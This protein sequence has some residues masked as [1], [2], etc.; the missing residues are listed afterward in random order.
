MGA[1]PASALALVTIP[2]MAEPMMEEEL[3]QLLSGAVDVLNKSSAPLVGGHSA[4]GA[5]LSIALTVTDA[6]PDY[7][8]EV[9]CPSRR[10]TYPDQTL[11][12]RSDSCGCDARYPCSWRNICGGHCMDSSNALSS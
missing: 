5:E 4:E 11:G 1:Q 9:W 3:Y 6:R 7:S 12:Y 10:C 8:Q 2:L